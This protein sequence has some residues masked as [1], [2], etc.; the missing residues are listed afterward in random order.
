VEKIAMRNVIKSR[1]AVTFGAIIIVLLL[2]GISIGAGYIAYK[3]GWLNP[4]TSSKTSMYAYFDPTTG[5]TV[6][7]PS[8]AE[9]DAYAAKK[10]VGV[11]G[12]YPISGLVQCVDNGTVVTGATVEVYVPHIPTTAEPYDWKIGCTSTTALGVFTTTGTG[13]AVGSTILVHIVRSATLY[14]YDR[15]VTYVV[16]PKAEGLGSSPIGLIEVPTYPRATP[17]ASMTL[18]NGTSVSTAVGTPTPLSKANGGASQTGAR[19]QL[20]IGNERWCTFGRDP[21]T[22]FST[23]R[24]EKRDY[25]TVITVSFN[26]TSGVSWL[27]SGWTGVTTSTATKFA[28]IVQ[29]TSFSP[30]V[31]RTLSSTSEAVL[32]Q[33]PFDLTGIT[34]N[35][36]VAI[37]VEIMDYQLWSNTAANTRTTTIGTD[38]TKFGYTYLV[39]AT[40]QIV[41]RA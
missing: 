35:A 27:G 19:T 13:F 8:A 4:S 29:S 22:Q 20:I 12:N 39:T 14:I 37:T 11:G 6:Y 23:S 18:G 36:G 5:Q 10:T 24:H 21:W 7:F 41:I 2:I 34:S 32:I 26:V 16:P 3:E 25:V 28:K 40:F 30:Y 33:T 15:W 17:T 31:I 1:R 9:R 38:S